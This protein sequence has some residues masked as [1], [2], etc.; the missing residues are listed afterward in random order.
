MKYSFITVIVVISVLTAGVS[1]GGPAAEEFIPPPDFAELHREFSAR[2]P[3]DLTADPSEN[4]SKSSTLYEGGMIIRSRDIAIDTR[5]YITPLSIEEVKSRYADL[6]VDRFRQTGPPAEAVAHFRRHLENQII[7]EIETETLDMGPPDRVEALYE[8]ALSAMSEAE[9]SDWKVFFNCYSA[10]YPQIENK[11]A[12]R[13]SMEMGDELF[14]RG[15]A[16]KA[17]AEYTIVHVTVSQPFIDN[18]ECF[19]SEET[20]ITYQVHHMVRTVE[21]R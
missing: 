5:I 4:M 6:I 9:Q 3:D 17:P 7:G 21:S 18:E 16:R 8:P 19:F 12:E 15:G 20:R 1:Y 13:F 11:T 14:Q 2:L 10:I